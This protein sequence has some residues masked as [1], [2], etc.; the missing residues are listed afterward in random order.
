MVMH[1][2]F[3][4]YIKKRNRILVQIDVYNQ[5]ATIVISILLLYIYANYLL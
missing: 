2:L 5:S 3:I 4:Y 1:I